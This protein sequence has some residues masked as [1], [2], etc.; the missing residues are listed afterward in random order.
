MPRPRLLT[1]AF[2]LCAA[3]NLLQATA[4]NL[5]LHFPGYLNQLGAD[6]LQIGVLFGLTAVA[7]ILAVVPTV[8][9]RLRPHPPEELVKALQLQ[10]GT[11]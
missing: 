4:F 3:A 6:D 5:F 2:V 11:R 10:H 7:A 9:L 8:V 1:R